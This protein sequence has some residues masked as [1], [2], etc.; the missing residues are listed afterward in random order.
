MT[1][2]NNTNAPRPLTDAEK[3]RQAAS[4]GA[5]QPKPVDVKPVTVDHKPVAVVAPAQK[6][7]SELLSAATTALANTDN[8]AGADVAVAALAT[9]A[10]NPVNPAKVAVAGG[11][12]ALVEADLAAAHK[13][14]IANANANAN[15]GKPQGGTVAKGKGKIDKPA[16]TVAA[17]KPAKLGKGATALANPAFVEGFDL[18]KW[19]AISSRVDD[20]PVPAPTRIDIIAARALGMTPGG[21]TANLLCLACYM[22]SNAARLN[23]YDYSMAAGKYVCGLSGDHKM[24]V[25]LKAASDG[26]VTIDKSLRLAGRLIANVRVCYQVKP[27]AKGLKLI[28]PALEAAKL[29]VPKRW[30]PADNGQGKPADKGKATP[31]TGT[32]ASA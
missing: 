23:L 20:K 19:P 2:E 22:S 29:Q 24:N 10:N 16:P 14:A 6:P 8:K 17:A 7:I 5:D 4:K 3:A 1:N 26:L 27:T 11:K 32:P 9:A 18:S 21:P 30:L 25:A 15:V 28:I 31:A 13:A 12:P